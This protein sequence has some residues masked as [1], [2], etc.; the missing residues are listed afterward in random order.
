M[1]VPVQQNSDDPLLL[2]LKQEE[3]RNSEDQCEG[4]L[5]RV[6]ERLQKHYLSVRRLIR[7]QAQSATARVPTL[8]TK[9]EELKMMD[10]ELDCLKKNKDNVQ[11][12]QVLH[13]LL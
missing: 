11:F 3:V 13:L 7:A 9:V 8:Q 10:A 4:V 1:F 6:T 5:V 2:G 12:L